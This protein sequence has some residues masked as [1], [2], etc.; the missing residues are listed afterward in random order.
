MRFSTKVLLLQ[1]ATVVAVV[2][3]CSGVF[4]WIS[5]ERLKSQAMDS[6]VSIARSV[7]E[8]PQVRAAVADEADGTDSGD[9]DTGSDAA[10]GAA[11]VDLAAG[12]EARTGA[13]FVVVT[14]ADGIRLAHPD[15]GRIGE[16]VSTDHEAALRGEEVTAWE[17]GTLG[18]SA[19]AK[20][21]VYAPDASAREVADSEPV[22]EVSVGFRRASVFDDLPLVLVGVAAAGATALAIGVLASVLMRRRWERLTL[23]VQPEELVALVRH[24]SAVLD[25]VDDGVLS[26]TPDGA[27]EVCNEVAARLLGADGVGV[28]TGTGTG[29]TVTV[30]L[31][32][33]GLP[34]WVVRELTGDGATGAR[35]G[36]RPASLD[37]V[38][39][40]D[41][42]LYL[43]SHP[44]TRAGRHLGTVVVVRDRTDLAALTRRLGT[45]Q[46]M[47]STLRVQRHEF[48]N[49]I[50]AASGLLDAGRI[51]DARAFLQDMAERGPV[52]FPLQGAELLDEPFLQSFLG[53]KSMEAGERGVGLRVGEETLV[54]GQIGGDGAVE[55]VAT[56]LGNLVDNAVAAA[57][58][59][60]GAGG[61]DDTDGERWVEVTAMQDDLALT[62]MVADS[63]P[64]LDAG[65][66]VPAEDPAPASDPIHGHGIGLALSR[67][68]LRRRGGELWVIDRGGTHPGHGAVFGVRLPGVFGTA[69]GSTNPDEETR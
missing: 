15:P 2:A 37:N 67:E 32:E 61:A 48:A 59:S 21:P 17:T 69:E 10:D 43:D 35:Q 50:H 42:V 3:V 30:T 29:S 62:L 19:R 8:D 36:A 60:D 57:L 4:T 26:V 52:D 16:R 34:A 41:R 56:V 9:R 12:V 31:A 20:V 14:D 6:A 47:G 7:A 64:G 24:Q 54:L 5:V 66:P 23:G 18:Q 40:G 51:D 11:L 25:G 65:D 53:G 55:D 46:A 27:V 45:V 38:V 58:R 1:L 28:G 39:V 44:V 63:G 13:L 33:L 68:M 49:R 22:G